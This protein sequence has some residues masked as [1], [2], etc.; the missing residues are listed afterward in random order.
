MGRNEIDLI[1][2]SKLQG[3]SPHPCRLRTGHLAPRSKFELCTG[4]YGILWGPTNWVA[5]CVIKTEAILPYLT[6]VHRDSAWAIHGVP[7]EAYTWKM[8]TRVRW[9]L[10]VSFT[11]LWTITTRGALLARVCCVVRLLSLQGLNWFESPWYPWIWV[12]I[13]RCSHSVELSTS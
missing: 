12:T 3:G 8:C 5:S 4:V 2:N 6:G 11:A 1:W 13:P 9:A 10:I 7:A